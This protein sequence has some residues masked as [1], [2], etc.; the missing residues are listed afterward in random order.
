LIVLLE[1]DGDA[2]GNAGDDLGVGTRELRLLL[3]CYIA[4]VVLFVGD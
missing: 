3:L 4:T 1:G 2:G